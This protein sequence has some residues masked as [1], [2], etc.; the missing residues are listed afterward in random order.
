[1]LYPLG[2]WAHALHMLGDALVKKRDNEATAAGGGSS[3]SGNGGGSA[4]GNAGSGG[5][6][7][8]QG[9]P[10]SNSNSKKRSKRRAALGASHRYDPTA[11]ELDGS[12]TEAVVRVMLATSPRDPL[13]MA[14]IGRTMLR[15]GMVE[16]GMGELHAALELGERNF[17][18]GVGYFAQAMRRFGVVADDDEDDR[19]ASD[20]SAANVNMHMH[21][22]HSTAPPPPPP[23]SPMSRAALLDF[24]GRRGG[25]WPGRAAILH[26]LGNAYGMSSE[27]DSAIVAFRAALAAEPDSPNA[28][29]TRFLLARSLAENGE[30]EQALDELETAVNAGLWVNDQLMQGSAFEDLQDHPR[31]ISI[32]EQMKRN[33]AT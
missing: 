28:A 1:M 11:E 29:A 21:G 9:G 26:A 18:G 30:E 3:G 8:R 12:N 23:P 31:F 4:W 13:L 25:D 5:G 27:T 17:R 2:W 14:E 32:R 20:P 19:T 24:A 10:K 15:L 16:E 22:R 7:G 33:A 6:D